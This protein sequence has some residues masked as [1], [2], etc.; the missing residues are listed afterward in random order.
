[1]EDPAVLAGAP[2]DELDPQLA[3]DPATG[4]V[5]LV[6][7]IQAATPTVMHRQAPPD[8]SAWSEP[9]AVSRPG[10]IAVRPAAVFHQGELR[11]VYEAHTSGFRQTPRQIVLATRGIDGFSAEVPATTDHAERNWPQVHS[12]GTRLW[13]EWID[14]EGAMSWMLESEPGVWTP[15]EFENFETVEE[16]DYQVRNRVK[17]AVRACP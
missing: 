2:D 14:S 7:W 12:N 6:Y 11:V 10:E 3:V 15:L 17:A 8:L 13:I 16:R 1:M 5:H 9:V 4:D